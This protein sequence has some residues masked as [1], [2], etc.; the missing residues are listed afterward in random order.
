MPVGFKMRFQLLFFL[1]WLIRRSWAEDCEPD[2]HVINSWNSAN[3]TVKE[4]NAELA[5]RLALE[6]DFIRYVYT[7]GW[8]LVHSFN[9]QQTF[10]KAKV[11]SNYQLI[12]D[13]PR[14]ERLEYSV[15]IAKRSSSS[16]IAY[17]PAKKEVTRLGPNFHKPPPY[18][19]TH[20]SKTRANMEICGLDNC[21]ENNAVPEFTV[22]CSPSLQSNADP[23]KLFSWNLGPLLPHKKYKCSTFVGEEIT[24]PWLMFEIT[25]KN[26]RN[27]IQAIPKTADNKSGFRVTL[28][29][30][31]LAEGINV[32][33]Y[34]PG[35]NT[36]GRRTGKELVFKDLDLYKIYVVCIRYVEVV[37]SEF[38]ELCQMERAAEVQ[39]PK[40]KAEDIPEL[41]LSLE[42]EEEKDFKLTSGYVPQVVSILEDP[43]NVKYK[44]TEQYTLANQSFHPAQI[45]PIFRPSRKCHIE[46]LDKIEVPEGMIACLLI[47]YAPEHLTHIPVSVSFADGASKTWTIDLVAESN[48]YMV[49]STIISLVLFVLVVFLFIGCIFHHKEQEI[50]VFL[51][52]G[53]S[54]PKKR[55]VHDLAGSVAYSMVSK[56]GQDKD[57]AETLG[58]PMTPDSL[59]A[60]VKGADFK[61]EVQEEYQKLQ[62]QDRIRNTLVKSILAGKLASKLELNRYGNIL[63]YDDTR[64]VLGKSGEAD[65]DY[66]NASWVRGFGDKKSYIATQDPTAKTCPHF[67]KMIFE[68][69]CLMIITLIKMREKQKNSIGK[70]SM[71]AKRIS[72]VFCH[73][74]FAITPF[75]FFLFVFSFFKWKIVMSTG[76]IPQ[77]IHKHLMASESHCSPKRTTSS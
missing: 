76:Q 50:A 69:Q 51:Q 73:F 74:M 45:F 27:I 60:F 17:F 10:P 1:L 53:L 38:S 6:T 23:Q 26:P 47:I 36:Q 40:F 46:Y 18:N 52:N 55:G 63:P 70:Y 57:I 67:W 11:W 33:G 20:T 49:A 4:I 14:C 75:L 28:D 25:S 34:I 62:D 72:C 16:P 42:E 24:K 65:S 58:K 68:N 29:P 77:I 22:T 15:F 37:T 35:I 7:C 21:W 31:F 61:A 66:I 5:G 44:Q 54:L 39:I 8:T 30:E 64:V 56:T 41:L 59:L 19:V 2:N 13:R 48:I 12:R 43:Q 9:G 3:L 32:Q 71:I